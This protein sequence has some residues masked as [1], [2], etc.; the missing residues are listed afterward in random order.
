MSLITGIGDRVKALGDKFLKTGAVKE[1]P[2]IP[3]TARIEEDVI[4][5]MDNSEAAKNL[6]KYIEDSFMGPSRTM[7]EGRE[8]V[9]I[10]N[11]GLLDGNFELGWWK[12]QNKGGQLNP[13]SARRA[14]SVNYTLSAFL[15]RAARI[16]PQ[17]GTTY[18]CRARGSGQ[19][20]IVAANRSEGLLACYL[21]PE[22]EVILPEWLFSIEVIDRTALR[23]IVRKIGARWIPAIT[24]I[25]S[26]VPLIDPVTA[27]QM[28][29]KQQRPLFFAMQGDDIAQ[30]EI[31]KYDINLEVM[32]PHLTNW[33]PTAITPATARRARFIGFEGLLTHADLF[34]MVGDP[35][36]VV[37]NKTRILSWSKNPEQNV[38][39]RKLVEWCSDQNS[40]TVPTVGV[41]EGGEE[42]VRFAEVILAPRGWCPEEVT[43]VFPGGL[44]QGL[45]VIYDMGNKAIIWASKMSPDTFDEEGMPRIDRVFTASQQLPDFSGTYARTLTQATASLQRDIS[46]QM[47]D[48]AYLRESLPELVA[49]VPDDNAPKQFPI[50]GGRVIGYRGSGGQAMNLGSRELPGTWLV[51]FQRACETLQQLYGISSL[52]APNR[53]RTAT[54]INN[55]DF[56]SGTRTDLTS[57]S[58][59]QSASNLAHQVINK[60]K[61]FFPEEQIIRVRGNFDVWESWSFRSADLQGETSIDIQPGTWAMGSFPA[62][63]QLAKDLYAMGAITDRDELRRLIPTAIFNQTTPDHARNACNELLQRIA[64]SG[65]LY[66]TPPVQGNVYPFDDLP[67]FMGEIKRWTAKYRRA[68]EDQTAREMPY[69]MQMFTRLRASPNAQPMTGEVAKQVLRSL[70]DNVTTMGRINA[71]FAQI[72]EILKQQN[73]SA[74]LDQDPRTKAALIQ[75]AQDAEATGRRI[76]IEGHRAETERMR[77]EADAAKS[78][79]EVEAIKNSPVEYGE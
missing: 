58:M 57:Y 67:V 40:R 42:T 2:S 55:S 62:T 12:R 10:T 73:E 71:L 14:V 5:K 18:T 78:E 13:K 23:A 35:D 46:R 29:D 27:Q 39:E 77:A 75:Q 7:R 65:P 69:V 49:L 68:I 31:P 26:P 3:A 66:D 36:V 6:V 11:M 43:K 54:E 48:L 9:W 59:R 64:T 44:K 25:P 32:S 50:P 21:T 33:D 53:G 72:A 63:W 37:N 79:A 1:E 60:I 28:V 19:R 56:L 52:V 47:T 51:L 74:Q 22:L 4:T 24:T 70:S 76:A 16:F 17:F 34:D 8:K 30:T 15:D 20:N 41:S 45:H 61:T 38:I